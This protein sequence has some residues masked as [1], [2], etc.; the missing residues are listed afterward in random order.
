MTTVDM[1][2][3]AT[4][5]YAQVRIELAT[6]AATK[7]HAITDT[8]CQLS[9]RTLSSSHATIADKI[10][11]TDAVRPKANQKPYQVHVDPLKL[12]RT[13]CID[14]KT[15][16]ASKPRLFCNSIPPIVCPAQNTT[17]MRAATRYGLTVFMGAVVYSRTRRDADRSTCLF[18]TKGCSDKDLKYSRPNIEMA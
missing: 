13:D 7:A 8:A 5:K 10:R 12:K 15:V 14:A 18:R 16:S 1:T 9:G 3:G 6:C 4:K 17:T 11:N 2:P